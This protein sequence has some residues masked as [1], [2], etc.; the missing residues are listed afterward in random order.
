MIKKVLDIIESYLAGTYVE[1][2]NYTFYL[3][4]EQELLFD[5]YDEMYK[6][7]KEVTELLNNEIPD[8]CAAVGEISIEE[9]KKLLKIEFLKAKELYER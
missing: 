4:L 6:E 8:I 3:E 2:E 7:D 5:N 1:D 9:F